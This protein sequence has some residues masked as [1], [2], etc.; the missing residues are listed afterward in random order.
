[1]KCYYHPTVDAVALCKSCQRALCP[2]CAADV[3]P[4]TACKGKCEEDVA[5]LNTMIQRGKTAYQKTGKAYKRNSLVMLLVGLIFFSI[6]II[7]ILA[8][9]GFDSTFMAFLGALFFLW[10]Y[11]S[12]KSGKQIEEVKGDRPRP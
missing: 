8:G 7:P 6:G 9:D 1:M 2:E 12:Y 5:A 3:P 10:S 11:F 4:G